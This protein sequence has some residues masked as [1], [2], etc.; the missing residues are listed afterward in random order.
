[1]DARVQLATTDAERWTYVASS[2]EET[3]HS[4]AQ[5]A[6]ILE[7]LTA[8]LDSA[9]QRLDALEEYQVRAIERELGNHKARE[10]PII[11][12]N[13]LPDPGTPT[14]FAAV[15]NRIYNDV[16]IVFLAGGFGGG[17]IVTLLTHVSLGWH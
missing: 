9:D 10:E 13:D 17:A 1:M 12:G 15:A 2:L 8:R 5:T 14:T 6:A 11:A 3:A 7:R 16:R 4:N